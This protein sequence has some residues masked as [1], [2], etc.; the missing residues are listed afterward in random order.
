MIYLMRHGKDNEDY[1]GGWSEIPLTKEGILEVTETA[2]FLNNSTEITIDKIISSS[3]KRA[4]PTADI[5]SPFLG[6]KE[7]EISDMLKEQSKGHLNG[8]EKNVAE[9]LYPEY[10]GNNVKVDTVYPDGESLENLYTRIKNNLEYF[11]SL[12]ENTLLITHRGVINMLYY[13]FNDLG[14]D[15]DKEK[16]GVT[17]ASVHECDIKNKTIRKVI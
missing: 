12:E 8:M 1:I 14:L 5:V 2:Q 13:I 4:I 9:H 3:I 6:I 11:A 7:F 16:F 10:T 17:H 15:M